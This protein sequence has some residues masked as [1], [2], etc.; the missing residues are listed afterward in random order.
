[1]PGRALRARA[2]GLDRLAQRQ[3][4]DRLGVDR[5]HGADREPLALESRGELRRRLHAGLE[6]GQALAVERA[7][8]SLGELGELAVVVVFGLVV[9]SGHAGT[10]IPTEGPRA[11][12]FPIAAKF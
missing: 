11:R 5:A 1:M 2:L 10:S 6:R 12:L 4:R 7:V 3:R 8:G 9:L